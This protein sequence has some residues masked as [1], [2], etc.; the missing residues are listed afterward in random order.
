[1]LFDGEGKSV[2]KELFEKLKERAREVSSALKEL[3]KENERLKAE[4]ASARADADRLKD[5]VAF[6][7]GERQELKAVVEELLKEFEQVAQ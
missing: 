7:E 4:A 6:Y 3:R 5:Q 1:M 2:Q